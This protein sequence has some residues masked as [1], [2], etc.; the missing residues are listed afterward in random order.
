MLEA[1]PRLTWRDVQGVLAATARKNDPRHEDWSFNGA[2]MHVNHWCA[3]L[4]FRVAVTVTV[5]VRV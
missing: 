2:G 1:N 3:L 5:T 4:G